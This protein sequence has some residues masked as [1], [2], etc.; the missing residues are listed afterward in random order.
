MGILLAPNV[1]WFTSGW[2]VVYLLEACHVG[3]E[4][5]LVPRVLADH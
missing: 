4:L 3:V 1:L 2:A 5:G